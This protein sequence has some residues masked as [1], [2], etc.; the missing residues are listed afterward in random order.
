M[1]I[2]R[3]PLLHKTLLALTV[4]LSVSSLADACT[5]AVYQGEGAL[6]VTGRTMDWRSAMPTNLWALPRGIAR[7]G[8]AGAHSMTW[9][10]RYGSVVAAGFDAGTADGMNE[11]GLVA[12]LLYLTESEY[13][14]PSDKDPRKTLSISLW[15]QHA[16]DNFATVA[17]AVAALSK[18]E[19][20]VVTTLTPDGKPGQLHL[21]L[22]DASGDSA[23]FQ[24]VG[25][26]LQIYHDRSYQVMTNSPTFDKQLA[27]NDYW[28]EIGGLTMLPGTNRSADRF[29]RASF[30]IKT[31]PKTDQANEA[32]AGVMSVMRNVSVPMGISTPDQPN[33][34]T[35][36]WRSVADQQ[37]RR[38]FFELTHLPNTFWVSMDKL[39][40]A[41]GAPVR[42]L[43][44]TEQQLYAGETAEKFV[45]A[46]AFRF[47]PASPKA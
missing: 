31:L 26:K 40:L 13:V 27:L 44:L 42:K 15:A 1:T 25:G 32:V 6:V 16:L 38:Y 43:P 11:K 20:Y 5:R 22:S 19:F 23:I 8:E 35:T 3:S 47:L 12:N 28:E 2:L 34:S 39:D 29:A 10:S 36:L 46:K 14:T 18:D 24:Y 7:E 17:E 21:S 4:S 9:T 33:I 30:Y 45:P 37:H 41:A